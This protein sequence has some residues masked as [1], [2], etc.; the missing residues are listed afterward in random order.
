MSRGP[1]ATRFHQHCDLKNSKFCMTI[2]MQLKQNLKMVW[3]V[4]QVPRWVSLAKKYCDNVLLTLIKV[5][6]QA[7]SRL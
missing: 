4:D 5:A 7:A 6:C 2:A 3:H 1:A